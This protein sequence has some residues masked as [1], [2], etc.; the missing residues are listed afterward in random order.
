MCRAHESE[1]NIE[2][3][4]HILNFHLNLPIVPRSGIP[5]ASPHLA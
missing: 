3:A 1:C 5:G 4:D 2:V